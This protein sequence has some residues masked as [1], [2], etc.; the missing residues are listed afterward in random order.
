MPVMLIVSLGQGL[1]STMESAAYK[2]PSRI[3][4]FRIILSL[5]PDTYKKRSSRLNASPTQDLRMDIAPD[6][7]SFF[8]SKSWTVCGLYPLFVT[9]RNFPE[10]DTAIFRGR[11]PRGR[12]FPTGVSDQP[13]GSSN[14]SASICFSSRVAA[15]LSCLFWEKT[16]ADIPVKTVPIRKMRFKHDIVYGL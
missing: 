13:L 9:A 4:Y 14:R 7:R 5:P 1:P 6:C 8:T 15:F 10:E 3:A 16:V 2:P 11:S 12:D